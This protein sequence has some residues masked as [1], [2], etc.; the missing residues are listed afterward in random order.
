MNNLDKFNDFIDIQLLLL[1][2]IPFDVVTDLLLSL[3]LII[4]SFIPS[5]MKFV[6]LFSCDQH[7][8]LKKCL[9]YDKTT[10]EHY[11]QI[12]YNHYQIKITTFIWKKY[13]TRY[14]K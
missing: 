2:E 3:S 1:A 13:Y 12:Q 10:T 6:I 8:A 7:T 9:I 11:I 14:L 4:H 5:N